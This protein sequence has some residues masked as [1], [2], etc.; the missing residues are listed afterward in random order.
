SLR[1]NAFVARHRRALQLAVRG[2][3]EHRARPR[4]AWTPVQ[5]SLRTH[6]LSDRDPLY[7]T[8]QAASQYH[9]NWTSALGWRQS[10]EA[11]ANEIRPRPVFVRHRSDGERPSNIEGFI[12][13]TNAAGSAGRVWPLDKVVNHDLIA[14]RLE[15]VCKPL[16]NVELVVVGL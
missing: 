3:T 12:V 4:G 1:R 14:E 11:L 7:K 16:G 15:P 8:V 2:D 10:G 5:A 9:S 6:C 13:M